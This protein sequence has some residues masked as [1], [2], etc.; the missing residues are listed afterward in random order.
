MDET[1]ETIGMSAEAAHKQELS[2]LDRHSIP[3]GTSTPWGGAQASHQYGE[4]VVCHSTASHGGF[5]LDRTANAKVTAAY[6]NASGFYEEDC[7]WA[8]VAHAFPHLFTARER[9]CA[10]KTLRHFWP[11]AY[12]R[13]NGTV[14]PAGASRVKDR[15]AFDERHR[16]HWVVIAAITSGHEPGF[17]ECIASIGGARGSATEQRYLVPKAEYVAGPHGF[18]ID[19]ARHTLYEGPSSFVTWASQT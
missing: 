3:S 7:E 5:Q 11:D 12:E 16:N 18:V 9:E 2:S 10:D 13:I 14:F 19:P 1:H 17:V 15:R 6:R 4:G 8:K